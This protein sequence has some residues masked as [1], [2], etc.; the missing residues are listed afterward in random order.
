MGCAPGAQGLIST[1]ASRLDLGG[2]SA[3]RRA[4]FWLLA[5]ESSASRHG[6]KLP[7]SPST[8]FNALSVMTQMSCRYRH[9]DRFTRRLYSSDFTSS[10]FAADSILNGLRRGRPN[11]G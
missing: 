11:T 4:L 1:I 3:R 9:D 6:K 7:I 8:V 2:L 5:A 10:S